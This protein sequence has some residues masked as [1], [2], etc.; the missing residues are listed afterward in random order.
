M[1]V[2]LQNQLKNTKKNIIEE[3][4]KGLEQARVLDK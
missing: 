3:I 4:N 2:Q 1:I